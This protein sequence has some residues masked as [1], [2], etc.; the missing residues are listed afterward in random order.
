MIYDGA[1]TK[2]LIRVGRKTVKVLISGN[3][4]LYNKGDNIFLYWTIE[5]SIILGKENN[6]K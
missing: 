1:F 5:D 3:D 2:I 6:E 4:K